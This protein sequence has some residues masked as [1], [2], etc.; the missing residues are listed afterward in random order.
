[1]GKP[2]MTRE[3][4][5]AAAREVHLHGGS[6]VDLQALA[7]HDSDGCYYR[8]HEINPEHCRTVVCVVGAF[9]W[10]HDLLDKEIRLGSGGLALA[11]DSVVREIGDV[12]CPIGDFHALWGE[13]ECDLGDRAHIKA[14][15]RLHDDACT[16]EEARERLREVLGLE[17]A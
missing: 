4:V 6:E 16:D 11:G 17:P 13:V 5:I 12:V 1:M 7:G 3:A 8:N 15:Q 9:L 10:K 2:I 14:L